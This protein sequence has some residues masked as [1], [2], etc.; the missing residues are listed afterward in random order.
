MVVFPFELPG[1]ECAGVAGG[2]VLSMEAT[3]E[4]HLLADCRQGAGRE[5]DRA[6]LLAFTVMDGEEHGVEAEALNMNG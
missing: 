2:E 3:H 5:R 6:F 1:Q 4:V